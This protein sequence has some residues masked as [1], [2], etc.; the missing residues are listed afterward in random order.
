[1]SRKASE[2][3]QERFNHL[4]N[5]G[6]TPWELERADRD[7][8]AF[9]E[10]H[11]LPPSRAMDLGCGTGS[12]AIWLAQQGFQ[13]TGVDFS[14]PALE[15]AR[16][17]AEN[18]GLDIPFVQ[19]DFLKEKVDPIGFEFLFDRGCFHSFDEKENRRAFAENAHAHLTKNG[20]WLSFLGN[21]DAPPR[22]TGP[23]MRSAFDIILAVEPFFEILWLKSSFFD[24]ERENPARNWQCLMQKRL[25]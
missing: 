10:S 2:S 3:R 20:L 7:L 16:Q 12:N 11:P 19:K 24:S 4:Y 5:T 14:A 18:A 25:L 21:A 9:V 22:D 17:K 23:P 6:E 8:M 13:V 1:M 15:R